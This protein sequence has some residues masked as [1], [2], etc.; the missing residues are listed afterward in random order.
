MRVIEEGQSI[1]E[2]EGQTIPSYIVGESRGRFR[3]SRI[4]HVD[5]EYGASLSQLEPGEV[6]IAPGLIYEPTT[7]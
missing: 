1:G 6:I 2:H 3:F 4:A 5:V 7:T